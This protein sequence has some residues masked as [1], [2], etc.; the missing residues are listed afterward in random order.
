MNLSDY[1]KQLCNELGVSSAELARRTGQTP[2][3]LGRKINHST[4]SFDDFQNMLNA[5]GVKMEINFVLPGQEEKTEEPDKRL[6]TMISL[7]EEE[8]A[9]EKKKENVFSEINHD[10]RTALETISGSITLAMNHR[11]DSDYMVQCIKNMQTACEDISS[12]INR[13][14]QSEPSKEAVSADILK[15]RKVLLTD[16]NEIN[17]GIIREMLE[18]SGVIVEEAENG[19]E[20]VE[21]L[22]AGPTEYGL[23]FMDMI[24]PVM[25][26]IKAVSIIRETEGIS[27]IPIVAMTA[28]TSEKSRTEAF[29]AGI[30]D[31]LAKPVEHSRLISVLGEYLSIKR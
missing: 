5:L 4:L 6:L 26:G 1:I 30:N 14:S 21:K 25:N 3:N 19:A 23:V 8:L 27:D 13:N 10:F 18:D 28:E 12:L 2:Q 17:R 29:A 16:D 9:L 11:D 31:F 24:M 20:A 22:K 15:S 7:L